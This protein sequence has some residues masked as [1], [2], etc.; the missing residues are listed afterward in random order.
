MKKLMIILL[1]AFVCF[2][3]EAQ[4]PVKKDKSGNYY[5][6]TSAGKT[7]AKNTGKTFTDGKGIKYPVLISKNGKLFVIKTSKTGNK[8]N[9][10]LKLD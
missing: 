8:Y 9:Y 5:A 1:A 6:D 3:G 10:Y 4:Q 7:E 2:A